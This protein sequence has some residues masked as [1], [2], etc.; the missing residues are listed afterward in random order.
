MDHL[1][2]KLNV[3]TFKDL[4]KMYLET[5]T[6]GQ[7]IYTANNVATMNQQEM[8]RVDEIHLLEKQ[9]GKTKVINLDRFSKLKIKQLLSLE[10]N[11]LEGRFGGRPGKVEATDLSTFF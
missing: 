1:D 3:A 8:T 7:L 10:R 2:D 9:D 5:T 6:K 11:Y 4:C